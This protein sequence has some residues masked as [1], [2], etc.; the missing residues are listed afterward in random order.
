[1]CATRMC[2]LALCHRYVPVGTLLPAYTS[3]LTHLPCATDD[4]DGTVN[5]WGEAGWSTQLYVRNNL[6]VRVQH[7]L[8]AT[9]VALEYTCTQLMLLNH[10]PCWHLHLVIALATA[11]NK[12]YI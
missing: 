9:A 12:V 4:V 8:V 11:E 5:E 2:Q 7:I 3:W 6:T 10:R 1:M